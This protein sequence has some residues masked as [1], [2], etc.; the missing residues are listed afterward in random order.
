MVWGPEGVRGGAYE[1]TSA[2]R[3]DAHGLA[4]S[5]ARANDE[6]IAEEVVGGIEVGGDEVGWET[7]V[8]LEL[9]ALC[10]RQG[11]HGQR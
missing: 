1:G 4:D 5:Q 3:E 8:E 10:R 6:L 11:R 2:G 9:A 7:A